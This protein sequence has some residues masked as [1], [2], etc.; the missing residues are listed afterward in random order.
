MFPGPSACCLFSSCLL[1]FNK[2]LK[3]PLLGKLLEW[4]PQKGQTLALLLSPLARDRKPLFLPAEQNRRWEKIVCVKTS[5]SAKDET[6]SLALQTNKANSRHRIVLC[7]QQYCSHSVCLTTGDKLGIYNT[8]LPDKLLAE[9]ENIFMIKMINAF[10]KNVINKP[11]YSKTVCGVITL[12][13]TFEN[14]ELHFYAKIKMIYC[15]YT[16]RSTAQYCS[17]IMA[18]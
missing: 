6:K 13:Q 5:Q 18:Y 11:T 7:V 17:L 8:Y 16:I 4:N 10:N 1:D 14:F 15:R 2:R 3:S 12:W 9:N